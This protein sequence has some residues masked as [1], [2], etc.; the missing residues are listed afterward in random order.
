M[1]TAVCFATK[2][3]Y[4]SAKLFL[5][6]LQK[7]TAD[8]TFAEFI[9]VCPP[10]D[11]KLFSKL[12]HSSA[13]KISQKAL[14]I[15]TDDQVLR[16][17]EQFTESWYKQQILK[18][19]I[20]FHIETEYY[21]ILD[22]DIFCVNPISHN[23]FIRDGKAVTQMDNQHKA[24][25]AKWMK[26]AA[27]FLNYDLDE[28]IPIMEVTPNTFSREL[29]QNLLENLNLK[30]DAHRLYR[31]MIKH[32]LTEY[33][34]YYVNALQ[35]G[36]FNKYHI[37]GKLLH[38]KSIW[39]LHQAI[40]FKPAFFEDDDAPFFVFQS[41]TEV[42]HTVIK[43][44]LRDK[45]GLVRGDIPL[46]SC[47]MVTKNRSTLALKAVKCFQ[48][49]TYP[50]KEL[51]IIEDGTDDFAEQVRALNDPNIKLYHLETPALDPLAG[52][53]S[54]PLV[55]P[56]RAPVLAPTLGE[57][58]NQSIDRANGEY[59]IQWDD[60]DHYHVSRISVMMEHLRKKDV[61]AVFLSQ[62]MMA[63]PSRGYYSI[64]HTH[65]QGWEGTM[66]I[67]KDIMPRYPSM[68]RGEDTAFCSALREKGITRSNLDGHQIL[69]LY[70]IHGSNTWNEEHFAGMFR[71]TPPIGKERELRELLCQL[72]GCQNCKGIEEIV[73][74]PAQTYLAWLLFIVLV[75]I[76]VLL[77]LQ[78]PRA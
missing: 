50:N 38:S 21:L 34:L 39:Y 11:H 67:R 51:V 18:L 30:H 41:N 42:P 7:H 14:R 9:L 64:S 13:G 66:L 20:S 6:S 22:A 53:V 29:V 78:R 46:V 62:W 68:R 4:K 8:S 27:K 59:V 33:S 61:D 56:E 52:I 48:A 26:E 2:R 16:K 70:V 75:I 73:A 72:S 23:T 17:H 74:P 31:E 57:L 54:D 28:E 25:N 12:C 40:V 44:L 43:D 71:G 5:S 47:L 58:R 65:Q 1:I 10:A 77:I 36:L 69:Y 37:A 63:W 45:I 24:D 32:S 3:H 15:I 55:S 35:T 60:D 49:Q 19:W 76:L